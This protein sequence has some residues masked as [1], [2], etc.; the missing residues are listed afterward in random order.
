MRRNLPRGPGGQFRKKKPGDKAS[1]QR[2]PDQYGVEEQEDGEQGVD[3]TSSHATRQIKVEPPSTPALSSG[4]RRTHVSSSFSVHQH[5]ALAKLQLSA[6]MDDPASASLETRAKN[7]RRSTTGELRQSSTASKSRSSSAAEVSASCSRRST[8]SRKGAAE[9]PSSSGS[10]GDEDS[11]DDAPKRVLRPR[12]SQAAS[13]AALE[14][15][16]KLMEISPTAPHIRQLKALKKKTEENRR[17]WK[18]WVEI[19]NGACDICFAV[20]EE[21]KDVVPDPEEKLICNRYTSIAQVHHYATLGTNYYP[22]H[23]T[24]L[25]CVDVDVAAMKPSTA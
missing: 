22:L 9:S 4:T 6:L 24:L 18:G 1:E 23:S 13:S 7:K 15:K 2:S 14:A 12:I 8:R 20:H 10:D 21:L 11:E 16:N 19:P 17:T 3:E 25:F 5:E